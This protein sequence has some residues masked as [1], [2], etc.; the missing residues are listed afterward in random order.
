VTVAVYHRTISK[1][2]SSG[3][4]YA[5]YR[6]AAKTTHAPFGL[7]MM[8]RVPS[9]ISET[10]LLRIV[11][12]RLPRCCKKDALPMTAL[13]SD[14]ELEATY[15][16]NAADT[17]AGTAAAALDTGVEGESEYQTSPP[18]PPDPVPHPARLPQWSARRRASAITI[19]RSPSLTPVAPAVAQ[20]TCRAL[21][22]LS[23]PHTARTWRASC[24][25]G[26]RWWMGST[27]VSPGQ[28]R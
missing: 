19:S 15:A 2:R 12:N 28:P 9:D 22:C 25:G 20:S 1:Y 27:W 18:S 7:P 17:G 11:A 10:D 6:P 16:D 5:G 26:S 23:A 21:A 14:A 4:Y 24:W 13:D 8:F 3:Q